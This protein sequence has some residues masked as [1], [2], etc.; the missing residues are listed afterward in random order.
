MLLLHIE[1]AWRQRLGDSSCGERRRKR[2]WLLE[3][4]EAC[5]PWT[6]EAAGGAL[7]KELDV[8]EANVVLLKWTCD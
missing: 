7:V 2:T 8:L 4:V 3:R 5:R 6:G 1:R